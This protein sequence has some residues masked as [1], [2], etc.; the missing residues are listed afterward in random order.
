[1]L[2]ELY[3]A[4][5][6]AREIVAERNRQIARRQ[7]LCELPPSSSTRRLLVLRKLAVLVGGHLV[8]IGESLR[9][10][11]QTQSAGPSWLGHRYAEDANR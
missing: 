7:L 5:A 3:G 9:R 2:P 6:V 4:D 10:Y 1:M 11:G 8:A